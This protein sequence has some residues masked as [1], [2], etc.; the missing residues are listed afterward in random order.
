MKHSNDCPAREHDRLDQ[1][2]CVPKCE[3][4]HDAVRLFDF[5]VTCVPNTREAL[6]SF[7]ASVP[8]YERKVTRME[9]QHAVALAALREFLTATPG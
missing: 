3:S 1:C 8:L 5:A 9:A 7:K 6:A 2:E 4:L